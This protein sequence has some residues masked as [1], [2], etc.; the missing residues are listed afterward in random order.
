MNAT[1]KAKLRLFCFLISF[2]LNTIHDRD[3]SK[4]DDV[5]VYGNKNYLNLLVWITFK[6]LNINILPKQS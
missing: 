4:L 1:E 2:I 3:D 6:A 5:R